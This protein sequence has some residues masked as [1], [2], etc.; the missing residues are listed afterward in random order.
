[1][2]RDGFTGRL[3]EEQTLG[4]CEVVWDGDYVTFPRSLQILQMNFIGRW[5]KLWKLIPQSWSFL[6]Q[7]AARSTSTTASMVSSGFAE[8]W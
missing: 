1:M 8:K 3:F 2:S 7:W 5:Q 4:V 6:R